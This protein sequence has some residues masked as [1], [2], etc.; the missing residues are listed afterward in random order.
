MINLF[1]R[2]ALAHV[3][4]MVGEEEH[5]YWLDGPVV[6]GVV[7]PSLHL[8]GR[9]GGNLVK[10]I[11]LGEDALLHAVLFEALCGFRPAIVVGND[12][13]DQQSF[14]FRLLP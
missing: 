10:T 12:D 13:E 6:V 8:G 11:H 4:V 3:G 7:E 1:G 5:R 14:Q 2:D 9:G